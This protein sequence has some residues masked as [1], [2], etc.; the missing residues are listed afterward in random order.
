MTTSFKNV[1]AQGVG[2]QLTV[3]SVS[4][5]SPTTGYTTLIFDSQGT[6]PFLVGQYIVVSNIT[7]TGYNGTYAVT[8]CTATS[9]TYANS[10]TGA[11]TS[12]TVVFCPL[13]T[14]ASA[15]TTVIGFSLTNIT[16]DIIQAS[17]QLNDTVVGTTAY[18][19]NNVNIP[20]N[21]SIRIINGGERLVLGPSTNI[22]LWANQSSSIDL[23]MSYVEIS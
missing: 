2:I 17:V 1:L 22:M 5:A 23:V 8:A 20:A 11:A 12:G 9:V 19:I 7:I 18:F 16:P 15:R 4:S 14:N 6:A 13:T 3:T 21:T 10:T